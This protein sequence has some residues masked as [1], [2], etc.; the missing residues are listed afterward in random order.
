M[1]IKQLYLLRIF[2][3]LCKILRCFEIFIKSIYVVTEF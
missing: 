1:Y 3:F 2:F